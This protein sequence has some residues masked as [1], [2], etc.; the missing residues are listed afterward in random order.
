MALSMA[1]IRKL[2][3]AKDLRMAKGHVMTKDQFAATGATYRGTLGEAAR[4]GYY[5]ARAC[6]KMGQ[7]VTDAEWA[8]IQNFGMMMDCSVTYCLP[9][10]GKRRRPCVPVFWRAKT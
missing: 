1:K 2:T 4:A 3:M 6:E 10:N 8:D 7:S 5:T 9:V